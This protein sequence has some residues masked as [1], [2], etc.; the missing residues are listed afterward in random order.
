MPCTRGLAPVAIVA[1]PGAVAEAH[2]T[3]GPAVL[4]TADAFL[5]YRPSTV[6]VIPLTSTP[7]RFPSHVNVEPDAD[8]GIGPDTSWTM[9]P[10]LVAALAA[11]RIDPDPFAD[12]KSLSFSRQR[13]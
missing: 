5:R 7:R 3:R 1:C 9:R 4:A 10:Q 8:N 13:G 11:V 2:D 6:C 12:T